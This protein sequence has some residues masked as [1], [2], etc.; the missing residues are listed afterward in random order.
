LISVLGSPGVGKSSLCRALTERYAAAGVAVDHF[1]EEQ[2]LTRPAFA[3][4]AEEFAGGSG[5]VRPETL[6][7]A[8]REYARQ[9]RAD[10]VAVSITD[11]LIP[12]IPSLRAWG[13]SKQAINGIVEELAQ[14][15]RP[16]EVIIVHLVDDPERALRRAAAREAP[17]WIDWYVD[18]LRAAPGA[19]E[20][21]DLDSAVRHLNE[22]VDLTRQIL[23]RSGWPV[24]ELARVTEL[25]PAVLVQ[26]VINRL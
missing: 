10:G 6:I 23:D 25:D 22:E 15:V 3:A 14:A 4:V 21:V 17:G 26:T 5:I 8:T 16:T 18:K 2:I 11:A 24:I 20:V 9:S 19:T 1:A 7:T 12:F 13:H